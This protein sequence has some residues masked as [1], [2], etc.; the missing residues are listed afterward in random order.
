MLTSCN[1]EAFGVTKPQ[2]G[3][4]YTGVRGSEH[5]GHV[6]MM[7]LTV[8]AGGRSSQQLIIC[9]C[10]HHSLIHCQSLQPARVYADHRSCA[11]DRHNWTRVVRMIRCIPRTS[12]LS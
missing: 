9:T 3:R 10:L 4:E 2:P 12:T 5:V 8:H 6:T 11:D 7:L 1:G